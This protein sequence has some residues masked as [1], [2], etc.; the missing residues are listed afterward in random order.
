MDPALR[1]QLIAMAE[2]DQTV[3]AR[4]A[5]DGSLFKGYHPEMAQVHREHGERLARIMAE[6]GWPG[7]SL[8]GDDGAQAAWLIA[9]H[10]IGQPEGMRRA[11]ALLHEAQEKG[12]VPAVQAARLEDAVRF[13]EGRPQVYGTMYDWDAEGRLSVP[14]LEHPER[15]DARRAAV[16]LPPLAEALADMRRRTEETAEV[17]PQ[18]IARRKRDQEAWARSVGWR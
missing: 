12:A 3:R 5:A 15:V 13:H 6:H 8:A 16:G 4:L 7:V 9:M 14:M 1:V 11:L 17:P 18:D 10:A 2:R